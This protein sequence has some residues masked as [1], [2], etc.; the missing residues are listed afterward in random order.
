VPTF[1]KLGKQI[2]LMGTHG[3]WGRNDVSSIAPIP[4]PFAPLFKSG[5]P[6]I[7]FFIFLSQQHCGTPTP[8]TKTPLKL[9]IT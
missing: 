8:I 2:I 4:N 1:E 7:V 3:L 9:R 5:P 6:E